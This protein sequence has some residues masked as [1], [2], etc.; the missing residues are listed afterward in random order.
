MNWHVLVNLY[1]S[2]I[3]TGSSVCVLSC[4]SVFFPFIFERKSDIKR[5]LKMF[6]FFHAGK[7]VSYTLAGGLVGY[8]AGYASAL[9]NNQILNLAGTLFFITLGILNLVISDKKMAFLKSPFSYCSG[10]I[11]GFIPCG[12]FLGLLAYLAYV[13]NSFVSGAVGGLVF[14]LGNAINPLIIIAMFAPWCSKFIGKFFENP[15]TGKIA[16][17]L[18]FF[19][20]AGTLVWRTV[21]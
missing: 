19:F 4:G 16:G 11:V 9:R 3:L 15:W 12:A 10:F 6:L 18:V 14:G 20:W 8:S 5:T 2:G 7:L 17:S 1:I 21:A 13:A